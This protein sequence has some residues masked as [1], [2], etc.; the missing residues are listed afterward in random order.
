MVPS[1][2]LYCL[3]KSYC[4]A[5]YGLPTWVLGSK[6]LNT[7]SFNKGLRHVWRLP[8]NS[9]RNI[10]YSISGLSSLNDI[11]ISRFISCFNSMVL[12]DNG[13]VNY[14]A[15][16]CITDASGP[17]GQNLRYIETA[18]SYCGSEIVLM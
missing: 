11:L 18:I 1:N 4:C 3:I 16:N 6:C 9:H 12:I 10:L 8:Y 15:A 13:I 7:T 2:V 14:I 5:F 17:I